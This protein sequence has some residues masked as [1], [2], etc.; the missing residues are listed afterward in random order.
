MKIREETISA[1]K[2]ARAMID[3]AEE[4]ADKGH[5]LISAVAECIGKAEDGIRAARGSLEHHVSAVSRE[6]ELAAVCERP[7]IREMTPQEVRDLAKYMEDIGHK[8]FAKEA[9]K[10]A[11]EKEAIANGSNFITPDSP[12]TPHAGEESAAQKA[13]TTQADKEMVA[14][15]RDEIA[16]LRIN[17]VEHQA[18]ADT[19]IAQVVELRNEVAKLSDAFRAVDDIVSAEV[20]GSDI[21]FTKRSGLTAHLPIPQSGSQS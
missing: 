7:D 14:A 5:P 2:I 8:E 6:I 12:R 11:D 10:V 9:R 20:R 4:E 15:L 19:A 18:A 16:G 3:R 1:I 21:V 17:V 13:A